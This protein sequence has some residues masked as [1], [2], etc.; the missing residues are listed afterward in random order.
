MVS[1]K[2]IFEAI[3]CAHKYSFVLKKLFF[4]IYE[5]WLFSPVPGTG[6]KICFQNVP[7]RY[8]ENTLVAAGLS[9]EAAS[10]IT[11][12]LETS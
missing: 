11:S 8:F 5:G 9:E 1:K 3:K 4:L 7:F 6:K 12:F 2:T 10:K